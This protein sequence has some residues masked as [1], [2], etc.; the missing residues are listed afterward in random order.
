MSSD[1]EHMVSKIIEYINADRRVQE[2]DP[3]TSD[4]YARVLRAD[5]DATLQEAQ[6]AF[7]NAVQE[8]I[9]HREELLDL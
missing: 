9:D 4:Y 6:S 1:F 3:F 8:A 7:E 2:I 5:R